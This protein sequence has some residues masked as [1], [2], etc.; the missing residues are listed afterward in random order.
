VSRSH[1]DES[2]RPTANPTTRDAAAEDTARASAAAEDYP[3][4]WDD[5]E[6][7]LKGV[8][9]DFR[10]ATYGEA[11]LGALG[12]TLPTAGGSVTGWIFIG[13]GALLAGLFIS[14]ELSDWCDQSKSF[15]NGHMRGT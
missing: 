13:V 9:S 10:S 12:L 6:R 5:F 2:R 11:N 3:R 8:S 1:Y 4:R 7:F 15:K 14:T